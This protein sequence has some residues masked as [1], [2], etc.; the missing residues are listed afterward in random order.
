MKKFILI[1][2]LITW[3]FNVS[4]QT[5]YEAGLR[6]GNQWGSEVAI[7]ATLPIG[8]SPRFHPALY[9]GDGG[10][11]IAT[12]FDWLFALEDGPSGLRLYPGVGP[13]LLF[14]AGPAKGT[15]FAIAGNFGVEYQFEFPLTISF[16]WRPSWVIT[17]LSGNDFLADFIGFSAR[18][19][20]SEIRL[21]R[22]KG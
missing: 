14:D 19:R 17:G 21:K 2:F 13:E 6:F 8:I 11:G 4:G 3:T 12:Y 22:V 16:D 10:L 9:L 7:D 18:Y 5:A 15:E 20:F 1:G